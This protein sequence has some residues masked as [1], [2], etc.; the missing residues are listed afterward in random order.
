MVPESG[1]YPPWC[2]EE[3]YTHHGAG[4]RDTHPIYTLGYPPWYIHHPTYTPR[5]HL[6]PSIAAGYMHTVV[7][8]RR[9]EALGSSLRLITKMRRI[10]ASRLLKV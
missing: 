6:P 9:E 4:R 3:E 1:V 10:E 5:V 7:M 2:R 8:M